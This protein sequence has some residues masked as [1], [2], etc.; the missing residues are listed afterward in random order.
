LLCC[1]LPASKPAAP[2]GLLAKVVLEKRGAHPEC[3]VFLRDGKT[4][5]FAGGGALG[6]GELLFWDVETRKPIKAFH[7]HKFSIVSIALSPDGK[8]I[9]TGGGFGEVKVWDTAGKVLASLDGRAEYTY[10]I[11]YSPDGKW[12]AY[13]GDPLTVRETVGFKIVPAYKKNTACGPSIAFN[14]DGKSLVGTIQNELRFYTFPEWKEASFTSTVR[15]QRYGNVRYA[16]DGKSVAIS[17][18]VSR[19]EHIPDS[20]FSIEVWSISGAAV[21][22]KRFEVP[23]HFIGY[24][25]TADSKY[26]VVGESDPQAGDIREYIRVIDVATGKEAVS[27]AAGVKLTI[28][29]LTLSPDGKLLVSCDD[30]EGG[31][32]WDFE[33]LMGKYWVDGKKK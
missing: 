29:H 13:T 8:Q 21:G 19:D 7:E 27:W 14:P 12:L 9:A 6:P 11:A 4:V 20:I 25:F 24:C 31:K 17:T 30:Y 3:A 23:G 16:P 22:K 1:L 5:A 15:K 26:L 18:V 28:R 2:P 33:K 32:V 10:G